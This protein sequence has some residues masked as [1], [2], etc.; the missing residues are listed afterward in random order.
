MFLRT[1]GFVFLALC[2]AWPLVAQDE[3]L[4]AP[5]GETGAD[6]ASAEGGEVEDGAEG[7]GAP[8]FI[9]VTEELEAGVLRGLAYLAEEQNEDG[10]FNADRYGGPHVGVTAICCLAFLANG[11]LPGGATM[12]TLSRRGSTISSPTRAS[13][14]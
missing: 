8:S 5:A 14:G 10:S 3:A 2:F 6:A 13:P 4:V 9:E 11:E 1:L 12:A 7:E